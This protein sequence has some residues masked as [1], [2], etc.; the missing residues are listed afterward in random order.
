[1]AIDVF[2]DSQASDLPSPLQFDP[3]IRAAL[4]AA[5]E[6]AEDSGLSLC[7]RVVDEAEGRELNLA[8]RQKDS[9]TNVLSFSGEVEIPGCRHVGDIVI[10]APVVQREAQEQSKSFA[11]HFAHLSIH[12]CLHL[13]GFDH[14]SDDE[15]TQ[16]EALEVQVLA[17]LGLPDPYQ[18]ALNS[19]GNAVH[20]EACSNG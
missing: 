4:A 9:A 8:Y 19:G 18:G 15:A 16:M 10:C 13:L 7:L 20:H 6:D 3:W 5:G 2:I 17:E 12:G 11:A 1:M 14:Q